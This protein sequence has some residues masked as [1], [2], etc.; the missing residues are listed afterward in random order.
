MIK[1]KMF[2]GALVCVGGQVGHQSS[3]NNS[4]SSTRIEFEAARTAAGVG[5]GRVVVWFRC[6]VFVV[7]GPRGFPGALAGL[8][9]TGWPSE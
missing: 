1:F 6:C 2:P 8:G 3:L 7:V 4:P 5:G 9:A